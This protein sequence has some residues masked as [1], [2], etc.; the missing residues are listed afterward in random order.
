[1]CHHFVSPSKDRASVERLD[2]VFF[3]GVT[4]DDVLS[5]CSFGDVST[6]TVLFDS[7]RMMAGYVLMFF[8]TCLMLGKA[9]LIEHR[10]LLA[11]AGIF[12]V[13][14]GLIISIGLT[15]AFG[16]P[17]TTI[18]GIMPFLALGIGIDDMFVI[19]QCMNNLPKSAANRPT[20]DRIALTM[21][22]AGVAITVTSLTDVL[23]FGVGAVTVR[24]N[25]I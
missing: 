4:P 20:E 12:S 2:N 9:N 6:E 1:M 7:S 17:Y 22:H 23:A 13:V 11:V 25:R 24:D 21:K 14:L 16:F 5:L 3:F 8:Y 19:L 10:S 18:H 15:M